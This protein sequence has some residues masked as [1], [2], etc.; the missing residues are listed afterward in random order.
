MA[1]VTVI[2]YWPVIEHMRSWDGDIGRA[3]RG[4]TRRMANFQRVFVPKRTGAT[5]AQI[6]PG[7][8]GR[9]VM[10]LETW[11]GANP[12]GRGHGKKGVAYWQDQG[13]R[14]HSIRPKASNTHGF[15]VFFWPKVGHV[16]HFKHVNHPG[17]PATNWVMRGAEAGMRSWT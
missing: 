16:V 11:V 14:P 15:M 9:T 12:G 7:P 5:M 2:L 1:T 8:E 10:G 17:N 4:L 3:T 6:E 13:T